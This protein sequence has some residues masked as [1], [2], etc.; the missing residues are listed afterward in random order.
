MTKKIGILVGSLREKSFN[1]RVANKLIEMMPEGYE[2]EL[3]KYDYLPFYR[4]EYDFEEPAEYKEF[5]DEIKKYDGFIF[6]IPEYN[7]SYP[8]ALKNAIDVASRPYGKNLWLNKPGAVFSASAGAMG[9]FGAAN[10]LNQVLIGLGMPLLA[11]PGVYIGSVMKAFEKDGS[12]VESTAK[13]L[14]MAVNSFID[15]LERNAR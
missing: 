8:G 6:Q 14:Q 5:R 1:K 15:H 4:E 13:F 7:R 2:A 10:H 12:L 11:D 3:I 9:G